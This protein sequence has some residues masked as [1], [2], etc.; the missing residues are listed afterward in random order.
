MCLDTYYDI[1]NV[2]LYVMLLSFSL[3][4]VLF[5]IA[6]FSVNTK[7]AELSVTLV[8]HSLCNFKS[9]SFCLHIASV[10]LADSH[11]KVRLFHNQPLQ[12]TLWGF[13]G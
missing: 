9:A 10:G 13:V 11:S 4:V 7:M 8:N 6:L 3:K 5:L 1:N 12:C 2:L